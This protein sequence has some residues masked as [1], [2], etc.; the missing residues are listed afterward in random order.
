M[1][2]RAC[3][4]NERI[5][6]DKVFC[7]PTHQIIQQSTSMG[8][9]GLSY[10]KTCSHS[11][12]A[13]ACVLI[14]TPNQPPVT[15][16]RRPALSPKRPRPLDKRPFKEPDEACDDQWA[17]DTEC[18][19]CIILDGQPDHT[20]I[21]TCTYLHTYTHTHTRTCT[22][23]RARVRALEK[24]KANLQGIRYTHASCTMLAHI[25]MAHTI[26]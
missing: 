10:G 13:P 21:D 24:D 4:K 5:C 12:R 7:R 17:P 3:R 1:T 25:M 6:F 9:L 14:H 16:P 26:S 8:G 18:S 19:L 23:T 11:N 15:A 22:H 2:V 20:H